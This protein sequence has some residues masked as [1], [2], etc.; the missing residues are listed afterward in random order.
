MI[1]MQSLYNL[2]L[3]YATLASCFKQWEPQK[4]GEAKGDMTMT[5]SLRRPS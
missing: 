4:T 5:I 2:Y 1:Q 3:F